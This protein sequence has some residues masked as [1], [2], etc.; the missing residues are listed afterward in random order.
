MV[1]DGDRDLTRSSIRSRFGR[2]TAE[3]RIIAGW[4]RVAAEVELFALDHDDRI[5]SFHSTDRDCTMRI[6]S[7]PGRVAG[8]ILVRLVNTR[9][10]STR[11]RLSWQRIPR[12]LPT[13]FGQARNDLTALATR[14]STLPL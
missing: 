9:N 8:T 10:H 14:L 4:S 1:D 5:T 6:R 7:A 13:S 11:L 2:A 3:G 12:L